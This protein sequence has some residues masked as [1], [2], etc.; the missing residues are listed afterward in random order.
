MYVLNIGTE[1]FE[2]GERRNGEGDAKDIYMFYMKCI[3]NSAESGKTGLQ[4]EYLLKVFESKFL[5]IQLTLHYLM[6]KSFF[7]LPI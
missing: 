5:H 7:P 2:C 1:F 6:L 3:F 4:Q